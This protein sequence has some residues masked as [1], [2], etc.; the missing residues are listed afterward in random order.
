MPYALERPDK[1]M[2]ITLRLDPDLVEQLKALA[3]SRNAP[4]GAVLNVVIRTGLATELA[5]PSRPYK[6]PARPMQ[7]Q[8]GIDL[9][10]ALRLADAL[11]DAER[12]RKL[13]RRDS[14]AGPFP[15]DA[16]GQ[17]LA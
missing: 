16:A 2:R 8:P 7:L 17:P 15:T 12:I 3:V 10:H 13:K 1:R 4:L 9:T 5:S 14:G 6:I 11:D